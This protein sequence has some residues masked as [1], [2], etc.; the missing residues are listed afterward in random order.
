MKRQ[1]IFLILT[2]LF[3]SIQTN[4]QDLNFNEDIRKLIERNGKVDS[5]H[6]LRDT[7][8]INQDTL[9]VD[10]DA[11][12]S[13]QDTIPVDPTVLP[14]EKIE[15]QDTIVAQPVYKK[16]KLPD[17]QMSEEAL[18]WS[19]YADRPPRKIKPY[20]RF[21][22]TVIVSPLFLPPLFK[23]GH[24]MPT[25]ELWSY[26]PISLDDKPWE[27]P[28]YKPV[29]I[30]K[31]Q[32]LKLAIEEMAYRY[33]QRNAPGVF[34]YNAKYLPSEKTHF[35]SRNE[36]VRVPIEKKEISLTENTLPIFI[37]NRRF[38]TSSFESA[39]KFTQNYV[40][41]NWHQGGASS[42]NILTMN[43]VKY[44]YAKG[45]VQ[46]NN[47]LEANAT[48]FNAPNDTMRD[49]RIGN[50]LLRYNLN[51]GLKAFNKWYY[52]AIAEFKTQMFTNYKENTS[53][54]QAAFLSPYTFKLEFGMKYDLVKP[55]KRKDCSLTLV[56][57]IAPLSYSYM[58]STSTD[59]DLARHGFHKKEGTDTYEH[60]LS[61]FG[62]T[63][64]FDMTMKPQRNIN[65]T[66]RFYYFTSYDRVI[67]EFENRLDL[68][69]NRYFSTLIILYFR[70]DDGV[71]KGDH[72]LIQSNESLS[73]GLSYRW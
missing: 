40:S 59:I 49:Y 10:Q 23:E 48:V 44:N 22:D 56:A 4:A 6:V 62:S 70:F 31:K 13:E 17:V 54:K 65:W 46:F 61:T 16:L 7:V 67:G 34:L 21:R 68:A 28:L 32:R 2:L 73:F 12:V 14:Q 3:A 33:L 20:M 9:F 39:L 60:K 58:Y 27:K 57:N 52:T 29:E 41:P 42:M 15:P 72:S 11:L 63:L 71:P 66:S 51:V 18:Y 5:S 50:D 38:W 69:L 47:L 36:T 19:R 35:I 8:V 64:R 45:K 53:I 25:E 37:P 55:F 43:T 1:Y 26:Q 24:V 30:L